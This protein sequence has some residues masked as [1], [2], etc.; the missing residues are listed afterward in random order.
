MRRECLSGARQQARGWTWVKRECLS[1]A[2]L[3]QRWYP[4]AGVCHVSLVI[5]PSLA[6]MLANTQI[7]C[8]DCRMKFSSDAELRRHRR[9][10]G[11][12][13]GVQKALPA[14]ADAAVHDFPAVVPDGGPR[15]PGRLQ[16]ASF[17]N[18]DLRGYMAARG[19]ANK[20]LGALTLQQLQQKMNS[21]SLADLQA[22]ALQE[23]QQALAS[24]LRAYKLS[25]GSM[26]SCVVVGL[27]VSGSDAFVLDLDLFGPD[28]LPTISDPMACV[29]QLSFRL[30]CRHAATTTT[31][32]QAKAPMQWIGVGLGS[33]HAMEEVMGVGQRMQEKGALGQGPWATRGRYQQCSR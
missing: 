21:S 13:I 16:A 7:K 1:G 32:A 25:G 3:P 23:E 12:P 33:R 11:G 17:S 28:N 20:G 22:R 31:Q 30:A 9:F 8:V 29:M 4:L 2:R 14:A 5:L 6:M 19:D 10:C 24:K 18:H 27:G 15:S 26:P